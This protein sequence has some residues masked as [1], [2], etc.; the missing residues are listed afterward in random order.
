[1]VKRTR[2]SNKLPPGFDI[3]R[4]AAERDMSEMEDA[5]YRAMETIRFQ[6]LRPEFFVHTHCVQCGVMCRGGGEQR[7][8][9][10]CAIHALGL[11]CGS[12]AAHLYG[13]ACQKLKRREDTVLA[14]A[15]P[16]ILK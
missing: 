7:L 13:D 3:T 11:I 2:L 16:D 8:C 4:D 10:A 14:R 1:M 12:E 6:I 9:A 15:A 5:A